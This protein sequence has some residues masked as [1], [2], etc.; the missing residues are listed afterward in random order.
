MH[1]Q[2]EIKRYINYGYIYIY[3]SLL[4]KHR[5]YSLAQIHFRR[6]LMNIVDIYVVFYLIRQSEKGSMCVENPT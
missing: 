1:T 6:S 3:I 2:Y 5:G 4:G